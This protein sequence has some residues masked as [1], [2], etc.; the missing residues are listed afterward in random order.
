M[1]PGKKSKV[2]SAFDQASEPLISPEEYSA[3]IDQ[4]DL[5][6]LWLASATVENNHGRT[7][8][9][10]PGVWI[11]QETRYE[12]RERGFDAFVEY[13]LTF[14]GKGSSKSELTVTFGVFF[15][16]KEPMTNRV[17]E[18]FEG[19]NLPL[20]TWPFLR[21]F[22]QSMTARMNWPSLTLPSYKAGVERPRPRRGARRAASQDK[23]AEE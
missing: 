17:F 13:R 22:V 5:E 8:P 21:E 16:S 1:S 20:N 2:A 14:E 18:I 12:N 11:K 15:S 9:D 10:D 23:P 4:I 3:F 19:V 7:P 6:S